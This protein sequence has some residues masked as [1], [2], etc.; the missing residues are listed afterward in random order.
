[1]KVFIF[2]VKFLPFRKHIKANE[3]K[4]RVFDFTF[5]LGVPDC[6]FLDKME[7]LFHIISEE[8]SI[9]S[10]NIIQA[11]LVIHSSHGLSTFSEH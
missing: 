9:I 4:K 6:P 5:R 11:I 2:I 7:Q 3:E 10:Q 8:P 1:M